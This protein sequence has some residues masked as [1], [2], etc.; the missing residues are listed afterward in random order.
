MEYQLLHRIIEI[1]YMFRDNPIK[2]TGIH[3]KSVE[4]QELAESIKMG[5]PILGEAKA[6]HS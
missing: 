5:N 6:T 3:K 1:I 2:R 4:K